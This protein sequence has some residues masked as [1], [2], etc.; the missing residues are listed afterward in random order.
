MSIKVM[1]L[2]WKESKLGGS[3][4]LCL[5]AIADF[6]DDNGVAYPSVTTLSEKIRMSKRNTNY[7]LKKLETSGELEIDRNKGRNGC[8]LFRVKTLQGAI[9]A[10]LQPVS[11]GGAT[12]FPQGVQP[13]APEPSLN[14]QEPSDIPFPEKDAGKK[15]KRKSKNETLQAFLDHCKADGSNAV[16]VDDPIFD[17]ATT[18]GLP[19]NAIALAWFTFKGQF[20]QTDNRQKDW[21]A[22]F[23]NA[24]RRN[25]FK[26]WYI[27]NDGATGLTTAGQ[28]AQ[29][30][31][32]ATSRMAA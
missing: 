25:W 22:H 10:P 3:E 2:V 31:M 8:N 17:Y 15:Q 28:Q 6:A 16:P 23:R 18:V 9:S 20:L 7:I 29:R 5:L 14:R 12:G 32:E 21:R 30:E 24:V 26:L 4:L 11:Q 19:E 27:G 13:I 1:S